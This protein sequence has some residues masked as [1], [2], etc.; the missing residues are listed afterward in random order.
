LPRPLQLAPPR[1]QG[2]HPAI[3]SVVTTS[4]LRPAVTRIPS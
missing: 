4:R 1:L 2:L 3:D